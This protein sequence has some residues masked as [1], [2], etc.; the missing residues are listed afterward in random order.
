MD[1]VERCVENGDMRD[2]ERSWGECWEAG[3]RD[4][5]CRGCFLMGWI[6]RIFY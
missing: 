6:W 5:Y 1:Y 4:D 3:E 2:G